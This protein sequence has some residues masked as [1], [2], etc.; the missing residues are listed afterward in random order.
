MMAKAEAADLSTIADDAKAID[1]LHVVDVDHLSAFTDGDSDLEAELFD[2]YQNTAERYLK[3]METAL[4]QSQAWSAEAHALK[5]ASANLG[6]C[7]VAALAKAA[8][9]EAPSPAR[10]EVLRIAVDDVTAFF[11]EQR[12]P[13]R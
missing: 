13:G 5:G 1:R 10:L 3:G 7:R 2:L 9:F 4:G 11:A 12:A 8:E 6:A